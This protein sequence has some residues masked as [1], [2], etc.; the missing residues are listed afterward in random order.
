MKD[1]ISVIIIWNV[2]ITTLSTCLYS[3]T[4]AKLSL[5][6]VA[7]CSHLVMRMVVFYVVTLIQILSILTQPEAQGK[8]HGN[9]SLRA[10]YNGYYT[11][12][13][14]LHNYYVINKSANIDN[15]MT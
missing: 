6:T 10:Y 14:A 12:I 8:C 1:Q 2:T 7:N 4:T 3:S 9:V 15:C 13:H 5:T 11:V